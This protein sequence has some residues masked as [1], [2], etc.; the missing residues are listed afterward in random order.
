M[1]DERLSFLVADHLAGV[2]RTLRRLGLSNAEADDGAQQ[3][4]LLLSRRLPEIAVGSE[5]AFLMAAATRVAAGLRRKRDRRREIVDG[6]LAVGLAQNQLSPEDLLDQHRARC[7]LDA[8]LAELP[9]ELSAVLVLYEF[10]QLSMAEISVAL[11]L[12][13][14]TVASRLR[15]ARAELSK[16]I[17]RLPVKSPRRGGAR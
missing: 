6:D 13:P 16:R 15:R 11:D 14:G 8:L 5:R 9:A 2:W 7:L 12:R 3:I 10:E 1:D 17:S 4:M